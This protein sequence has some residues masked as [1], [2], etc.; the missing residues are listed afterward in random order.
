[1]ASPRRI[2][3]AMAESFKKL[4]PQEQ[5]EVRRKLYESITRKSYRPN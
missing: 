1:M 3:Y 4:T 2:L 5:I